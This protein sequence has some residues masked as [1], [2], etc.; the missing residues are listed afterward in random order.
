[1][2]YPF[3][4]NRWALSRRGLLGLS[5]AALCAGSA[6]AQGVMRTAVLSPPRAGPPSFPPPTVDF[7]FQTMSTLDARISFSRGSAATYFDKTGA[8]Q[9]AAI[10]VPR[11]DWGPTPGSA[12]LGLLVEPSGTN[13]L[14]N[15]ATLSTQDVPVTFQWYTLS[16]FGGGSISLSGATT[17]TLPGTGTKTP[18]VMQFAPSAGTL[19]LTVSGS[20]LNAQLEV[21]QFATSYIPTTSATATRAQDVATFLLPDGF[22]TVTST[23]SANIIP[24]GYPFENDGMIFGATSGAT[25]LVLYHGG[26]AGAYL[27]GV[28]NT[29]I[30]PL[31]INAALNKIVTTY[32]NGAAAVCMNAGPVTRLASY[33]S[34]PVTT[35]YLMAGGVGDGFS[36]HCQSGWMQHARLWDQAFSDADLVRLTT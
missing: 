34:P 30:G 17:A 11:F 28:L 7:N 19:T 26:T 18:A 22:P 32:D 3:N 36:V 12:P 13:L 5:A 31:A 9:V 23:W 8:P 10:D 33:S 6:N 35:Y 1:M 25:P 21:G 2:S 15:S 4:P 16:F 29:A 27:N 20:V 14:L 24:Q